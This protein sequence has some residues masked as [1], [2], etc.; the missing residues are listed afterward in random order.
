[1]LLPILFVEPSSFLGTYPHSKYFFVIDVI[2]L[3]PENA[4]IILKM[5]ETGLV[6]NDNYWCLAEL[7]HIFGFYTI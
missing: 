4:I 1:M 2:I 3:H 5:L 7:V 6:Q